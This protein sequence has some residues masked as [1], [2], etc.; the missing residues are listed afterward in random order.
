MIKI[1][2]AGVIAISLGAFA[3]KQYLSSN[4]ANSPTGSSQVEQAEEDIDKAINQELERAKELEQ[5]SE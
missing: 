2:I 5:L 4:T 3:A 1:L